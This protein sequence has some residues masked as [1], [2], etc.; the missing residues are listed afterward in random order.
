MHFVVRV[1]IYSSMLKLVKNCDGAEVCEKRVGKAFFHQNEN[2]NLFVILG[3]TFV[4]VLILRVG[5]K[6]INLN[7]Y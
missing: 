4:V 6:K 7:A 1:E 5:Y 2:D 3:H